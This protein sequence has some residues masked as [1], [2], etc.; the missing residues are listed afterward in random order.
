VVDREAGPN[1]GNDRARMK[2]NDIIHLR[3]KLTKLRFGWLLS[4]Q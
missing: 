1:V 2:A 3:V 4:V